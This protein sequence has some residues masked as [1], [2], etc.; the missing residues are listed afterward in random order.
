MHWKFDAFLTLGRDGTRSGL[1]FVKNKNKCYFKYLIIV[2][3]NFQP[4]LL[5]R[6]LLWAINSWSISRNL[7]SGCLS[8]DAASLDVIS[9]AAELLSSNIWRKVLS[10]SSSF[11]ITKSRNNLYNKSLQSSKKDPQQ[12]VQNIFA[13]SIARDIGGWLSRT[14]TLC[15]WSSGDRVQRGRIIWKTSWSKITKD[16]SAV[17]T[18]SKEMAHSSEW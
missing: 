10:T 7:R 16:G 9:P 14:T 18:R 15:S 12:T 11:K 5:Y 4:T 1:F 2:K 13:P 17:I 6:S 8:N 3:T